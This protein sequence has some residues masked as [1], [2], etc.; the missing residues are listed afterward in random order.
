MLF[1]SVGVGRGAWIER[2]FCIILVITDSFGLQGWSLV[3]LFYNSYY[4]T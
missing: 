4:V 1:V 3:R 2:L